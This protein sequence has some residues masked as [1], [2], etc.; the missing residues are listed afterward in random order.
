MGV[1][2]F[3]VRISERS[4]HLRCVVV[5]PI[6][7][8]SVRAWLKSSQADDRCLAIPISLQSYCRIHD[9]FN[10]LGEWKAAIDVLEEMSEAGL[11]MD[12]FTYAHAIEACCNA[13]NRVS[14]DSPLLVMHSLYSHNDPKLEDKMNQQTS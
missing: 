1:K 5:S 14:G 7:E 11:A 4:A 6:C 2:V 12:A 8:G 13:G 9:I 10:V 3:C